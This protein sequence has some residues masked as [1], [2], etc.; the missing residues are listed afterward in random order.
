MTASP[1]SADFQA[2]LAALG[3]KHL[4]RPTVAELLDG[5]PKD[6]L[7][8]V[9]QAKRDLRQA[10]VSADFESGTN[11]DSEAY[12]EVSVRDAGLVDL[13]LAML[14][15]IEALEREVAELKSPRA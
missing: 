3:G 9:L 12:A 11:V 1:P 14:S 10:L 15:K 5:A 13:M 2:K 8:S 4:A 7:W 6:G